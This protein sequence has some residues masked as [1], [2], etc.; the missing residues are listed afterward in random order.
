MTSNTII[1]KTKKNRV[2]VFDV[3]TTGLINKPSLD[4]PYV[5]QLSFIVY[6]KE[7]IKRPVDPSQQIGFDESNIIRT[8]NEYIRIPSDVVLTS[9]ITRLTGISRYQ[10]DQGV[11]MADALYEFYKEYEQAETILA[12]N[13]NFDMSMLSIEIE[14]NYKDLILHKDVHYTDLFNPLY[15]KI[16]KKELYCT[17]QNGKDVCNIWIESRIGEKTRKFKKNPKLQELYFK[18]FGCIPTGLH[19]AL[20]DTKVCLECYMQMIC[21]KPITLPKVMTIKQNIFAFQP[22]SSKM[23]SPLMAQIVEEDDQS[24]HENGNVSQKSSSD[25]FASSPPSS[26]LSCT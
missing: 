1:T 9:E 13:I 24:M 2:L 5:I 21:P 14:R 4:Q 10:C 12:H 22:P 23:S 15:N 26:P 25:S 11:D 6:Q 20:V 3:E 18:L 16:H 17:M 19:D 7:E 8:Y